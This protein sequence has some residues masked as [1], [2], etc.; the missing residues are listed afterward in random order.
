MD[1]LGGGGGA[2]DFYYSRGDLHVCSVCLVLY[3]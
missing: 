2:G 3:D 1:R